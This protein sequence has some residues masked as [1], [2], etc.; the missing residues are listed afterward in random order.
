MGASRIDKL[1]ESFKSDIPNMV[2]KFNNLFK[3]LGESANAE[4][5][6][7][8]MEIKEGQQ[9]R[10]RKAQL[11]EQKKKVEEQEKELE[12]KNKELEKFGKLKNL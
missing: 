11:D 2:G 8:I 4:Q 12:E 1:R 3:S 9:E 6:A 5:F 10:D 7:S